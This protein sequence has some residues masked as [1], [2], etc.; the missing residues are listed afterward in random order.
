[1]RRVMA[2]VIKF[3]TRQ[4]FNP[5]RRWKLFRVMRCFMAR[6]IYFYT[7]QGFTPESPRVPADQMGK[8]IEFP[9]INI[10]KSA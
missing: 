3:Y 4:G 8:L 7:R 9:G 1:M 5:K 10:K 6:V 2:R